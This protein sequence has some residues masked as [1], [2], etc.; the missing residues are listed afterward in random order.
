MNNWHVWVFKALVL[1]GLLSC[2]GSTENTNEYGLDLVSCTADTQKEFV[3]R[4]MQDAYYWYADLPNTINY[5]D[6]SSPDAVVKGLRHVPEDRFSYVTSTLNHDSFYQQGQYVGFGFGYEFDENNRVFIRFVYTDSPSYRAGLRRGHEIISIDSSPISSYIALDPSGNPYLKN[7]FGAATLGVNKLFVTRLADSSQTSYTLTK[8]VV[9]INTVLTAKSFNHNGQQYAYLAFKNFISP[10]YSE[11]DSAFNQFNTDN[12]QKLI[13]D[14]RY[15][16]G[17]S[18][19]VAAALA[20][21]I[22]QPI[23]DNTDLFTHLKFNDKYQNENTNYYFRDYS[24]SLNLD[25]VIVLTSEG[26]CSASEMVI[27]ALEPFINVTVVGSTTCGKP[28]GMR[29]QSFCSNKLVAINFQSFN[30]AGFGDY[31]NGISADCAAQDDVK[32]DLGDI[33]EPMLK[34]ALD[35]DNNHAICVSPTPRASKNSGIQSPSAFYQGL[36]R[37]YASE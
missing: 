34:A 25:E 17:G 8:A 32:F 30:K 18:V 31:F 11:L 35:Y 24:N 28:I 29:P 36:Q 12:A 4:A 13:L 15:N 16:G 27:N 1:T 33:N 5:T 22:Y 3:L 7:A 9:T 23:A 14:L 10:S 19:A 6:Y 26:T 20:S 37:E 21:Y 2:S